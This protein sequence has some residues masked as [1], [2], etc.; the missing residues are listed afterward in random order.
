MNSFVKGVAAVALF[1]GVHADEFSYE[2]PSTG[3]GTAAD[4]YYVYTTLFDPAVDTADDTSDDT[5]GTW[6]VGMKTV[7]IEDEGEQFIRL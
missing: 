3:A 1:G 5:F 2:R 7:F 4:E 6:Q